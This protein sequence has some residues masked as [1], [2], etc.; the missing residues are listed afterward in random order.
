MRARYNLGI[1]LFNL[2][3]Y[4]EAVRALEV[5]VVE[6][7]CVRN[8][9]VEACHGAAYARLGR[10]PDAIA[11]LRMTRAMTPGME[12]RRL[13]VD[14]YNSHGVDLRNRRIQRRCR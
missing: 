8:T 1:T 13:L 10:W 4:D 5:L 9:M 11:Q 6:H 3:R 7:R 14:A 2:K 12:A